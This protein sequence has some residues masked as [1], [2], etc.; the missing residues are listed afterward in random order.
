MLNRIGRIFF[1]IRP[2]EN[3]IF[4]ITFYKVVYIV[5]KVWYII[6]RTDRTTEYKTNSRDKRPICNMV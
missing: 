2:N 3:Q 4:L 5:Y 1:T 6:V